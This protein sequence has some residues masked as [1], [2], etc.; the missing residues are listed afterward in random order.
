MPAGAR[1]D[2]IGQRGEHGR[3]GHRDR[4]HQ[5]GQSEALGRENASGERGTEQDETE[6]ARLTKEQGATRCVRAA[7]PKREAQGGEHDDLDHDQDDPARGQPGTD[8]GQE[9]HVYC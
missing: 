1:A 8:F 7:E 3:G 5:R 4:D 9:I 2:P 6:L